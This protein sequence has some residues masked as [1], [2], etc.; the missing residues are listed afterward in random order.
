MTAQNLS[1]AC[2]NALISSNI[3]T[4]SFEEK[5]ELFNTL[6]EIQ[7][8]IAR[9]NNLDKIEMIGEK[10]PVFNPTITDSIKAWINR[11][12]RNE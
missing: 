7:K 8:E 6:K 12:T 3:R 10:S 1:N 4:L 9:I 5:I 2:E 11:I